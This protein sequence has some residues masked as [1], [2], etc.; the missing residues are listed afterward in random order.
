MVT[1]CLAAAP[2]PPKPT[3]VKLVEL[4]KCPKAFWV[5]SMEKPVVVAPGNVMSRMPPFSP[6][7]IM[8]PCAL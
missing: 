6:F 5:R 1:V 4:Q 2:E 3:G 7:T 8:A